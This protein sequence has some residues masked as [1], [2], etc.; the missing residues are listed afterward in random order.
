MNDKSNEMHQN[1]VKL[2]SDRYAGPLIDNSERGKYIEAM[3]AEILNSD[4]ELTWRM[5]GHSAWSMWDIENRITGKKIEVKQSAACQTWPQGNKGLLSNNASPR[6]DIKEVSGYWGGDSGGES[7]WINLPKSQRLADLYVFAWHRISD[8][9][10]ANH[11]DPAQWEFYVVQV[12]KLPKGQKTI[13]L[14]PLRE[15]A[16]YA[17]FKNLNS[18]V[19]RALSAG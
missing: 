12:E 8:R 9:A 2:L 7:V 18:I 1:V 17:D 5:A 11:C 10:K 4:W 15:L 19:E 14:N 16:V 13:G 6:F 3:V